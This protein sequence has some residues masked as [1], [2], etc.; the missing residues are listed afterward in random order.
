[1]S[2]RM[3]FVAVLA[4]SEALIAMFA[5]RYGVAVEA[6]DFL[7]SIGGGEERCLVGI[8]EKYGLDVARRKPFPD[9]YIEAVRRVGADP[10][11]CLVVEDAVA[12]IAAARAAGSPHSIAMRARRPI[13]A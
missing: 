1:M 3:R 8:G 6:A 4:D 13:P 9:I 12:G 10:R 7:P 11:R 5:E 2:D